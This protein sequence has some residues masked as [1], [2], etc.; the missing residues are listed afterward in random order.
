MYCTA[1]ALA[2]CGY[3]EGFEVLKAFA[4]QT[5]P[6][7]KNI[8]PAGDILPDLS[9]LKDSRVDEIKILCQKYL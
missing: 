2:A 3:D 7:N 1:F 9:Y 5:H 6:L 4:N 8:H